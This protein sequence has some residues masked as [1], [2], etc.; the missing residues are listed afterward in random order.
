MYFYRVFCEEK[1]PFLKAL[2]HPA[3]IS[4]GYKEKPLAPSHQETLLLTGQ[5]YSSVCLD[6]QS[7]CIFQVEL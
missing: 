7:I 5:K 6:K 1:E 2:Q 4:E 3:F